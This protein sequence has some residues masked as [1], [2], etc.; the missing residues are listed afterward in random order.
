M[1]WLKT[2]SITIPSLIL[3]FSLL[4]SCQKQ[5]GTK[6]TGGAFVDSVA[7]AD[8]V[9]IYYQ[10][11]GRGSPVL[12]FVHGWCADRTYWDNQVPYFKDKVEVVTIDLAGHG[13]SG[14]NRRNWTIEAFGRDV[15]AVVNQLDLNRFV[16]I[17]HSMGGLVIIEA[18]RQ[19]PGRVI[20]L[21]GVDTFQDLGKKYDQD[22]FEER[23]APFKENFV[24]TTMGFVRSMYPE[25]ADS[26][27]VARIAADIASEPK[28]IAL[29]CIEGVYKYDA[30]AALKEVRLPIIAIN[31]DMIPTN[32]EGNR[33][34]AA[35]FDV[36]IMPG[37]GH[38]L[39][40]EDPRDFNPK[41]EQAVMR[42]V[43]GPAPE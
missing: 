9:M 12:V 37:H 1:N 17:G 38:F 29:A 21:V 5:P 18:A 33:K 32:V 30:A 8:S 31:S 28:D 2:I 35:S 26:A 14:T 25:D 34:I 4:S 11:E 23:L 10:V 24:E 16:L 13:Q 36:I 42:L 7:S 15:A 19:L 27:L 6:M 41:L 20:G 40:L 22:E 3:A 43:K 39:M